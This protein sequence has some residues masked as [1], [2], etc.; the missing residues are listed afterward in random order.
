MVNCA[1]TY[2]RVE[3][4]NLLSAFDSKL[5]ERIANLWENFHILNTHIPRRRG[6]GGIKK[7]NATHLS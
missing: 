1:V 4:K 5:K 6:G 7:E 2:L 3:T